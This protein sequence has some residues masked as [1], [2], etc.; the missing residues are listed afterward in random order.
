MFPYI[1]I[2]QVIVKMKVLDKKL[3]TTTCKYVK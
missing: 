1:V 2:Q 3:K